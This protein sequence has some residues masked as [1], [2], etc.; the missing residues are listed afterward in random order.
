VSSTGRAETG[1][2]CGTASAGAAG[3]AAFATAGKLFVETPTFPLIAAALGQWAA[4]G[5]SGAATVARAN[6]TATLTACDPG[7]A[8]D[9]VRVSSAGDVLDARAFFLLDELGGGLP[10]PAAECV[11]ERLAVDREVIAFY[12]NPEP[13]DAEFDAVDRKVA[14]AEGACPI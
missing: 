3:A 7:N 8:P 5:P 2:S 14:D 6:N 4:L 12:V 11:A 13:S 9:D 10:V 1:G